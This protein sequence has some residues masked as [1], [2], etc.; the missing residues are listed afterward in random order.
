MKERL[1]TVSRHLSG[2]L[3]SMN[4]RSRAVAGA[5]LCLMLAG[6][7]W[8]VASAGEADMT[9]LETPTLARED[10]PRA[11]D[12]LEARGIAARVQDGAVIVSSGS[13]DAARAALR[14]DGLLSTQRRS[15]FEEVAERSDIW[16]TRSTTEKRWQAAKMATLERLIEDFP[17]VNAATVILE[18]GSGRSLG[19]KRPRAAVNV[20]LSDGATVTTEL[21]GAIA[22]LV[23]GSV[24]AMDR[25]D[26]RIVDSRGT[27]H[28][29]GRQDDTGPLAKMHRAE[30]LYRERIVSALR[31]IDDVIVSMDVGTTNGEVACRRVTVSLPRSHLRAI[32]EASDVERP[33]EAIAQSELEQIRTRVAEVTGAE[34]ES[35]HVD[36]YHDAAP[37]VAAVPPDDSGHGG[38]SAAQR[39]AVAVVLVGLAVVAAVTFLRRRTARRREHGSGEAAETQQS[40]PADESS[41]PFAFC[42]ETPIE[43]LQAALRAEH[44][45]TVAVV[46]S[47]LAPARSAAVLASLEPDRRVEV[48]RRVAATRQVDQQMLSEVADSLRRR[49]S[50][51]EP[52]SPGG[53]VAAAAG[54]LKHV[55][56]A[57]EQAILDALKGESPE[58]ARSIRR[59]LMAFDDI[60]RLPLEQLSD[61]LEDLD[62]ED[63]AVALRTANRRLRRRVLSSV[64]T[65]TSRRVREQMERIGPVRLSDVE[66]AQQRVVEAV[67]RYQPGEYSPESP[68]R[69]AEEPTVTDAERSV[70]TEPS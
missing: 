29:A 4:P 26:V 59:E 1:K 2:R 69:D 13:A 10:L 61:V 47:Y 56:G 62:S 46:L 28:V 66:A 33:R 53:G 41:E 36:W 39:G 34:P 19:G 5:L 44:P 31:Y 27:S 7:V 12:A 57:A 58:L 49:L 9:R 45:Q 52:Q 6:A 14:E 35:V 50:R 68:S 21:I 63:L 8:L 70:V 16:S 20:R 51:H 65:A 43:E 54:I 18:T 15:P 23:A 48:V 25:S 40:D 24:S 42:C 17:A 30:Q 32:A 22:D 38:F 3:R 37:G 67:R 11:L 60:E 55:G 64:S